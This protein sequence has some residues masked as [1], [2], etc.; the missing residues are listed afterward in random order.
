MPSLDIQESD[1]VLDSHVHD[2]D[3]GSDLPL[4]PSSEESLPI[5]TK[6]IKTQTSLSQYPYLDANN[7]SYVHSSL[8]LYLECEILESGEV[9][10][11]ISQVRLWNV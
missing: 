11:L 9:L 3:L 4:S 2:E 8:K 1:S 6:A 10:Q 7:P 5:L